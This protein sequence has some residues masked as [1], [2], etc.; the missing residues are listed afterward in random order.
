MPRS[1][2]TLAAIEASGK[3]STIKMVS[4]NGSSFALQDVASGTSPLA[5]DVAEPDAWVGYAN[6]DQAFRIM[7]GMP[8]VNETTPIRIFTSSNIAQAGGAPA[9]SSGYG[10]AYI[11]GFYKLWGLP[12]PS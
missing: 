5:A 7:T 12:S 3:S 8:P 2:G 6:M 11:T 1:P 10:T 9:Y 4:F